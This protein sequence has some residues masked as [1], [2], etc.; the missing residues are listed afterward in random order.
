MQLDGANRQ[1]TDLF[2]KSKELGEEKEKLTQLLEEAQDGKKNQSSD[3]EDNDYQ[4]ARQR[5]M[6]NLLD[7]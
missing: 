1:R 5:E 4:A 6:Q 3:S 2:R 7:I